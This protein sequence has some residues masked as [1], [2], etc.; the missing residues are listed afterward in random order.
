MFTKRVLSSFNYTLIPTLIVIYLLHF[1]TVAIQLNS[2][3]MY[4]MSFICAIIGLIWNFISFDAKSTLSIH[5]FNFHC[6]FIAFGL[7]AF[8]FIP[9]MNA[10]VNHEA[11]MTALIA[12][13]IIIS[14][15]GFLLLWSL[16]YNAMVSDS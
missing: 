11:W 12:V 1:V 16:T 15:L 7:L 6:F 4:W 8:S 2:T 3:A 9:E 13:H 5:A 14:A 10:W